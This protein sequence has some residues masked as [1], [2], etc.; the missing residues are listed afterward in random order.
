MTAHLLSVNVG[1]PRDIAW[2][3]KTVHTA[4]WKAPVQGSRVVRRLNIDGDGQGDLVGHGGEHRA[5]FVY[6][7]DSYRYWQSELGR[8]GFTYGQFR[9]W[10]RSVEL[11]IIFPGLGDTGLRAEAPQEAITV[12]TT[13]SHTSLRSWRR[14]VLTNSELGI[15]HG[16]HLCP[17]WKP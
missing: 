3:G 16:H 12:R 15:S 2:R 5:A 8:N 6:Q 13:P 7:I 10:L 4:I 1:L 17:L 9:G 11:I 14:E